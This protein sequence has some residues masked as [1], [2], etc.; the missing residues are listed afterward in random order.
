MQDY[1]SLMPSF[2]L[3]GKSIND[4][5]LE[6]KNKSSD[7]MVQAMTQAQMKDRFDKQKQKD[8]TD[9]VKEA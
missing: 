6:F 9:I 8:V 7:I 3:S 4:L 2:M 1:Y 5:E